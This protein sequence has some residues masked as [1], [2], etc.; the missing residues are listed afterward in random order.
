[1]FAN[2]SLQKEEEEPNVLCNVTIEDCLDTSTVED[3]SEE[4]S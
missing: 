2:A 1:M 4:K 3:V